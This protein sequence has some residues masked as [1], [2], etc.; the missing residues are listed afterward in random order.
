MKP[1]LQC[2]KY[3]RCEETT[4]AEGW[5]SPHAPATSSGRLASKALAGPPCPCIAGGRKK[6]ECRTT[7]FHGLIIDHCRDIQSRS[8]SLMD[9]KRTVCPQ[10]AENLPCAPPEYGGRTLFVFFGNGTREPRE[11]R[12]GLYSSGTMPCM[13]LEFRNRSTSILRP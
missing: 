12:A 9:H 6:K 1:E 11:N 4:K 2:R 3:N 7:R 13:T 8:K 5:P 10:T